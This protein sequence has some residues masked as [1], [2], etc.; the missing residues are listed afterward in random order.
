MIQG[1]RVKK[2]IVHFITGLNTG[3]AEIMLLKLLSAINLNKYNI[4]VIS[5]ID[6][7]TIGHKIESLGIEVLTLNLSRKSPVT[8][9]LLS[10]PF[11][12]KRF[13]PNIFHGWMY[14]ANL[15]LSLTSLLFPKVRIIWGIRHSL[16]DINKEKF[17][18][19]LV[20]YLSKFFSKKCTNIIFNSIISLEQHVKYGFSDN[21]CSVIHNGFDTKK[22][23]PDNFTDKQRNILRTQLKIPENTNLIGF[24]ARF[25]PMKGHKN[26][27]KAAIKIINK[28]ENVRFLIVGPG[29]TNKNLNYLI[30]KEIRSFFYLLG[31]RYDIAYLNSIFDISIN[32]S[33]WGEGFSNSICESMLMEVPCIATNVGE[34]ELILKNC[35]VILH[36]N[37]EEVLANS[38]IRLLS[39]SLDERKEIGRLERLRIIDNFSIEVITMKYESLYDV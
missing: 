38:L 9:S 39:K 14:H 12:L 19:R 3:G 17:L 24:V 27:I 4:L 7:G 22:F 35:G 11:I 16:Y 10:L 18:T 1:L 15:L 21:N 31:E 37:N 34:A 25:H 2:N 5:L 6:K 23:S 29:V 36:S 32:C 13:K 30:P 26:F 28:K 20:I 8:L 33:S